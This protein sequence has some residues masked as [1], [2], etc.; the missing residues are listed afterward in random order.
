MYMYSI[1][2]LCAVYYDAIYMDY[3]LNPEIIYTLLKYYTLYSLPYIKGFMRRYYTVIFMS[4]K[5][6]CATVMVIES[7]NHKSLN[8]LFLLLKQDP[9]IFLFGLLILLEVFRLLISFC[10]GSGALRI[11]TF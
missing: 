1:M 2:P 3:V 11:E 4:G 9:N 7:V 5:K 8:K 10:I 6:S